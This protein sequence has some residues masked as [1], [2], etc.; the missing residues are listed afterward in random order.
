ME[1]GRSTLNESVSELV[2]WLRRLPY[3]HRLPP[4]ALAR[5][6]ESYALLAQTADAAQ[7]RHAQQTF[8]LDAIR[9]YQR[10][11][12]A[13]RPGEGMPLS[14]LMQVALTMAIKAGSLVGTTTSQRQEAIARLLDECER[15]AYA[16]EDRDYHRRLALASFI[17]QNAADPGLLEVE[18]PD[19][20]IECLREDQLCCPRCGA[21]DVD[22]SERIS[23]QSGNS[24]DILAFACRRCGYRE[25][26]MDGDTLAAHSPW[27]R[28]RK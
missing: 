7:R 2:A 23:P 1:R 26:S 18:E 17:K 9:S 16:P 10:P 25:V 8:L 27:A 15:E 21:E 24:G 14:D 28:R 5:L 19:T 20:T 4:S 11:E 3:T 6:F 12:L 22:S 13:L